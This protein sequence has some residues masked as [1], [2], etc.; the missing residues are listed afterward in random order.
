MEQHILIVKGN[1]ST[2][3][4]YIYYYR[5]NSYLRTV[6][7]WEEVIFESY[8]IMHSIFCFVNPELSSFRGNK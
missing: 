2:Q 7:I 6:K 5:R 8:D 1:L 4:A 3:V